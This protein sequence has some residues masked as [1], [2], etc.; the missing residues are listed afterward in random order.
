MCSPLLLVTL[1][2]KGSLEEGNPYIPAILIRADRELRSWFII[3]LHVLASRGGSEGS[4]G[5]S[6]DLRVR[7][8]GGDGGGPGNLKGNHVLYLQVT[9]FHDFP[10][11]LQTP[12]LR[13]HQLQIVL[14]VR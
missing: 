14:F 11:H 10:L 7:D 2:V 1:V 3:L 4:R 5:R 12:G 6:D 13:I 9:I 8:N